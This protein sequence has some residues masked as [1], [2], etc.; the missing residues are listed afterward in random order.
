MNEYEK[1]MVQILKRGRDE[2]GVVSVKA[3]FE[4]EGTRPDELLRLLDIAGRSSL[5]LTIKIGG[6]EAMWDL[7]QAQLFGAAFVVAPMIESPYALQKYIGA[8]DIVFDDSRKSDCDFLFNIETMQGMAHAKDLVN[9]AAEGALNGV[10]FGRSDFI[11]SSHGEY[12]DVNDDR[13]TAHVLEVAALCT[14][15]SLDLVV[16]GGVSVVSLPSLR[17]IREIGLTRFETR[18]VVFK[19]DA[20][21]M[22]DI[23][24][25]LLAAV[26][27]ELLWLINKREYYGRIHKEDERRINTLEDR[28]HVIADDII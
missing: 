18:K 9:V 10:V 4:A 6:C 22:P 1:K 3:E 25:G 23:E 13:V 14:G 26:H 28:W 15:A 16:G 12:E 2:S 20:L 21:D 17:K 19:S 24:R 27:F 11:G 7:M 8:R 5:P